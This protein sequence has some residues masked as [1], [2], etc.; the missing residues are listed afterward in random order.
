MLEVRM[1]VVQGTN[2]PTVPQVPPKCYV[3]QL[4]CLPE[5]F[6][7]L[8]FCSDFVVNIVFLNTVEPAYSYIVYSRFLAIVESS[9]VPFAFISLLLYP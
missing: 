8:L 4:L 5:C 3:P 9:L 6:Q 1:G 7:L 2:P